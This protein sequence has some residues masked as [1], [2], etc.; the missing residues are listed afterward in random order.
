MKYY[1][2]QAGPLWAATIIHFAMATSTTQSPETTTLFQSQKSTESPSFGS[3]AWSTW[4]SW[5]ACSRSCGGGVAFQERQCQRRPQNLV[6]NYT[7]PTPI[8][9]VRVTREIRPRD[10]T[11][12]SRRYHECN[13]QPCP[14]KERDRRAEQCS[15]YDRKPFRGRFYTWVP[16]I[17]GD[18]P[19]ALN[20][21]PLGHHFYASL[22]LVADGTPCTIQGYR[23][24]CIQGVC[25]SRG[26]APDL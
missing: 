11:G 1:R 2:W 21:R 22:A 14:G 20:C 26:A 7:L 9:T 8:I 5:S 25:K 10:C 16:Y 19:C 12:V 23:A 6:L 24:I 13:T 18:A 17:D 3:Y 4:G 15:T